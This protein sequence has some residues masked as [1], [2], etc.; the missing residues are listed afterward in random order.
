MY[1][2]LTLGK[3][4]RVEGSQTSSVFRPCLEDQTSHREIHTHHR[5]EGLRGW[6]G[7]IR[8][9]VVEY[10]LPTSE[11]S[12]FPYN[13]RPSPKFKSSVHNSF[14]D[15]G[16]LL[17]SNRLDCPYIHPLVPLS[18]GSLDLKTS[19]QWHLNTFGFPNPVCKLVS[20]LWVL[21]DLVDQSIGRNWRPLEIRNQE[22]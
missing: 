18:Y 12:D 11:Y 20:S 14:D 21:F 13:L 3:M 6:L 8:G 4:G 16:I 7:L 19:S 2:L 17:V 10:P 9:K 1:Q 15:K 5:K 22:S